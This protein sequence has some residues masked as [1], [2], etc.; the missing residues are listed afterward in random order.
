MRGMEDECWLSVLKWKP[1]FLRKQNVELAKF[2]VISESFFSPSTQDVPNIR[3][4]SI[5]WSVFTK[6]SV[7]ASHFQRHNSC[8]SSSLELC[9]YFHFMCSRSYCPQLTCGSEG[10]D[11]KLKQK[12]T[13]P[14]SVTSSSVI[15]HSTT[16][17][18]KPFVCSLFS[19][20]PPYIPTSCLLLLVD[21][22]QTD[23]G[24]FRKVS[25]PCMLSVT[26]GKGRWFSKAPDQSLDA[27]SCDCM[28]KLV[29][30]FRA[31][32]A[33]WVV[34]QTKSHISERLPY[35]FFKDCSTMQQL[36]VELAHIWQVEVI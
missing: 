17:V 13:L 25:P 16:M 9:K 19:F 26:T 6:Q 5:A 7:E 4:H 28:G 33:V 32:L 2:Y 21:F 11:L 10:S 31:I 18:T 29:L 8:P 14:P 30:W 34:S 15:S 36:Q 23:F 22:M 24:Y 3:R 12:Y 1:C 20:P 35:Y 27:L